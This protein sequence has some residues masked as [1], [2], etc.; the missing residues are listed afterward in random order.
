[1][2]ATPV[3]NGDALVV[4]TDVY[5]VCVTGIRY[6]LYCALSIGFKRFEIS[7]PNTLLTVETWKN[8][9]HS[10]SS[11]KTK[12]GNRIRW[13]FRAKRSLRT[14]TRTF[15]HNDRSRFNIIEIIYTRLTPSLSVSL[16]LFVKGAQS[17]RRQ[18]L[19]KLHNLP[20][21][22]P[23]TKVISLICTAQENSNDQ[24][25]QILDKVSK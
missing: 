25:V 18:S 9:F 5:G 20:L 21:E 15:P 16:S 10:K 19:A 11:G 7:R 23:I 6:T 8:S 3:L 4:R 22:A 1:M 14:F 2:S 24:V 12:N 13:G 17:A